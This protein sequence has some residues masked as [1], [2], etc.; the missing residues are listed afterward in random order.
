MA[1]PIR[2]VRLVLWGIV[3]LI[4]V[5][6]T[7]LFLVY[8]QRGTAIA[9]GIGNGDYQL[10]SADGAPFTRNSL[11]GHPSAVFFGFTHCPEVC[12]TTL[13][14]MTS[15]FEELGDEARELK[16]YFVS[17]DPERDTP[18]VIG[19]YVAWTG[20]VTGVSGSRAETDRALKSWSVYAKKIPGDGEDYNMDHTASVFLMDRDGN[21][22][23]TISY[24]E[25]RRA[26][27]A[28]LRRLL[29]S[30]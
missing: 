13:A 6:A 25:D 1:T 29:K 20:N 10:A 17:V 7:G 27:L 21:F 18:E 14:E 2:Q 4:A 24:R 30:T 19:A 3:A 12:P 22:E 26:A 16:A 28:K 5:A 8:G 9:T 11:V 15:W 23:G